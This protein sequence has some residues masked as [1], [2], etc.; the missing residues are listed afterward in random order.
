MMKT[1]ILLAMAIGSM[2]LGLGGCVYYPEPGPYRSQAYVA[3][4]PAAYAPP[5]AYYYAPSP[6]Y[7]PS[8][9][10]VDIGLGFGGGGHRHW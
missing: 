9:G 3:P 8:Y 4:P 1:T 2:A 6:Y 10:S 5:P 7:Y